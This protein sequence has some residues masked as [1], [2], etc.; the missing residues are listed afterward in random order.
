MEGI[1]NRGYDRM[2]QKNPLFRFFCAVYFIR[3]NGTMNFC[4]KSERVGVDRGELAGIHRV[5][6]RLRDR[7]GFFGYA[8]SLKA[9]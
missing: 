8:R 2:Q 5:F 3:S 6:L 7:A 9:G 4:A 1:M